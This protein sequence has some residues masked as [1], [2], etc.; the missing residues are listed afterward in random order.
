MRAGPRSLPRLR[1]APGNAPAADAAV[2]RE[3]NE[4][5]LARQYPEG[6]P[7]DVGLQG[8]DVSLS[9]LG[10]AAACGCGSPGGLPLKRM[11]LKGIVV[12][13]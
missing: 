5:H 10:K 4:V 12:R 3:L 11:L 9:K 8:R 13:A 1:A 2:R 6:L 7:W